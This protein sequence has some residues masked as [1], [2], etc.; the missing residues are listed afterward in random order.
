M[1]AE[2]RSVHTEMWRA[3]DWFQ[4]LPLDARLFWIYLFTNPSASVA[5][6]YRLPHSHDGI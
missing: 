4:E 5:G 6:I 3:D 1:A 2:Y